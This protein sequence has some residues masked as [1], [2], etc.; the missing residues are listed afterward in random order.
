[1]KRLISGFLIAVLALPLVT[2]A[3]QDNKK[4]TPELLKNRRMDRLQ[5]KIV[6]VSESEVTVSIGTEDKPEQ[7]KV[8]IPEKRR[9][10]FRGL[11]ARGW[12]QKAQL[13]CRKTD[14]G[15]LALVRIKSIEG[16][17]IAERGRRWR[18]MRDGMHQRGKELDPE[19]RKRLRD[20]FRSV[21]KKLR[22]NPELRAELRNLAKEDIQA[23]RQRIRRIH[24]L[25]G[26]SAKDGWHH[27]TRPGQMKPKARMRGGKGFGRRHD[28]QIRRLERETHE[29]A[30]KYSQA[31]GEQKEQLGQKLRDKLSETFDKKVELRAKE[32]ERLEKQLEKLHQRLEKRRQNREAIIEKRFAKLTK[33]GDDLSW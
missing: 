2:S 19:Q 5:G 15:G 18:G 27:P 9:A 3:E 31:E 21:A 30:R 24:E 17:Q 11:L 8:F 4:V 1:M 33:Q 32:V 13:L 12:G 7:A 28:P 25:A 10:E 20:R 14:E 22:E 16:V 23:F 6:S 26:E 29:L